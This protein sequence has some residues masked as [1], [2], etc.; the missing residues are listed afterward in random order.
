MT[1]YK[2]VSK[3]GGPLGISSI[4]Q[5]TSSIR[6]LNKYITLDVINK[7]TLC[8]LG[9]NMIITKLDSSDLSHGRKKDI[10]KAL[11]SLTL[12]WEIDS[13]T[14]IFINKLDEKLKDTYKKYFKKIEE[15]KGVKSER[16]IK[17]WVDWNQ[18]VKRRE[19]LENEVK[20]AGLFGKATLSINDY[21]LLQ[22]TLIASLYTHIPPRRNIFSTVKF[23]TW[24]E[25]KKIYKPKKSIYP[26][27]NYIVFNDTWVKTFL[28]LG[29]TKSSGH[30]REFKLPRR[31]KAIIKLTH[32]H[33]T[34]NYLLTK[35]HNR[36]LPLNENTFSKQLNN[37]FKLKDSPKSNIGCVSI[38][39][40]YENQPEIL[41]T[42][43]DAHAIAEKMGHTV[44]TA[45]SYYVK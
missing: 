7:N 12:G 9:F 36:T 26:P 43:S 16:D 42:L 5:Y 29:D 34:S 13:T 11:K 23:K 3:R 8:D 28:Y 4:K 17:N 21:K 38:R 2:F 10:M 30:Q 14:D 27:D 37:I 31:L 15:N 45:V 32:K 6:C 41:K 25:F 22:K 33:S 19:E 35:I 1:S 40:A 44:G 24:K 39:K 20:Q 18:L